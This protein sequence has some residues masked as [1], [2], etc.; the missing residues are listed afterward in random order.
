MF[1]QTF[2]NIDDVLWKEAG[3]TTELDYTEQTSWMLFLKY[4]D[5]LER[6]RAMEAELLGKPYEFIIDDAH[7]WSSWAVPKK[8]DGTFDHDTALT[9]DDLIAYVDDELF[10]CGQAGWRTGKDV[11]NKANTHAEMERST[12][13]ETCSDGL[14]RQEAMA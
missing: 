7:R 5:D 8:P 13:Q 1:E 9:G 11:L 10:P 3:C 4:L 12:L 6:E 14:T 2:K